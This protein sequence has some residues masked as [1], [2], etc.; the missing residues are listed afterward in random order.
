M[1]STPTSFAFQVTS[2]AVLY[3]RSCACSPSYM[4]WMPVL[5]V[6]YS[7]LIRRLSPQARYLSPESVSRIYT[8]QDCFLDIQQYL[9][10]TLD[11]G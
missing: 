1:K 3:K 7:P 6:A 5:S 8:L 9:W 11:N 4:D 10:L 2:S